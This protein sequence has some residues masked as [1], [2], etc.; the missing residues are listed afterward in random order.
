MWLLNTLI[1]LAPFAW[2]A[3][4]WFGLKALVQD[5]KNWRIRLS[6]AAL[7][8]TTIVGL[9]WLPAG[10]YAAHHPEM[11]KDRTLDA[12]TAIAVLACGV[13]LILSLFGKPRLIIPIVITCLGTASFWFGT[14][15]P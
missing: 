6:V 4:W 7:G 14:T 8:L 15:I 1:I 9:L 13:A 3:S 5:R 11:G 12:F 10:F 2:V